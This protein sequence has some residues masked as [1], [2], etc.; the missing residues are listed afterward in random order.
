MGKGKPKKGSS[1]GSNSHSE[2]KK[3]GLSKVKC[4]GSHEFGHYV[5]DFSERKKGEK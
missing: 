1:T 3:K 4:F 5:N 2:E